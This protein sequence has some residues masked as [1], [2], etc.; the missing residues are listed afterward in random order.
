MTGWSP[1]LSCVPVS[2]GAVGQTTFN[3]STKF[4]ISSCPVTF[5]GQ[6]YEDVY[7][8]F[9]SQNFVVCF[10]G[11]YNPQ[12]GG[13]C[14]LGP[15]T[16]SVFL[17]IVSK[18]QSREQRF[19]ENVP[20][21]HTAMGCN[22][23]YKLAD[24]VSVDTLNVTNTESNGQYYD[25]LDLSGC[26]H[27]GVTYTPD[28][29]VSSDPA[30]CTTLR[31]SRTA[32]LE[33][34]TCGP[35]ETCLSRVCITPLP[36]IC[37][38][39]GPTVIDFSSHLDFVKDRCDYHLLQIQGLSVVGYFLERRLKDV[40]FLDS[41][42]LE[43]NGV[44]IHLKQ[45][46]R[47]LV[48]LLQL[49]FM[50]QSGLGSRMCGLSSFLSVTLRS[51]SL[52][53]QKRSCQTQY[54]DTD[55]RYIHCINKTESCNLLKEAPFTSCPIDPEPYITACTD[56][57]ST[58]P[59]VDGLKCQFLQA[60]VKACSL[61]SNITLDGWGSKAECSSE[62]FCQDRTCSHH[63]FCGEKSDGGETC[64]FC[65]PIFASCYREKKALGDPTVCR[66][67]SASLT[68]I[69]CPLE[70]KGID[71][72]VLHLNNPTCRGQVDEENHMVTFSFNSSSCGT[73][74]TTNNNKVIYKNT[75]ITQNLS[76][77]TI[78]RH[79]QVNIK[80]FCIQTQPD[81][82]TVAFRIKDSSVV[83]EITSGPWTYTLTIKAFTDAHRTQAVNQSTEVFLNQKVW[84]ELDTKGLDGNLV[85]VVTESCWATDQI[86]SSVFSDGSDLITEQ[87]V[88]LFVSSCPNPAD[89]TVR[90]ESNGEGTSS[91][92][93]F[94][95]FEFTG[96]PSEVYLHC[97]LQLCVKQEN[98]C[99]PMCA[100]ARRRR[101]VRS[102]SQSAAF[103]SMAWTT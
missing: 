20:T 78:I 46:G 84:V 68:L 38:L 56:T 34:T 10:D 35:T 47:V 75:I 79:E 58:Y 7:I 18:S 55:D 9:T 97:S 26:R 13:D 33:N 40:S 36:S 31:C 95:M 17:N 50:S 98:S 57:L 49:Q 43:V 52:K 1:L 14:L 91:Y 15:E 80:F 29:D 85:S 99:V 28:T 67:N 44:H 77:S 76:S 60:Y 71:Y 70:D 86:D 96:G 32:V 21:I 30:T 89:P 66:Q 27:R 41:V 74:V 37:T 12:A 82:K 73:E 100:R 54:N 61:F 83:Q 72:S 53:T 5:Y 63:E 62:A 65:R 48:S 103:I 6:K 8:N 69:G 16:S 42:T 90:V 81:I 45:G 87:S 92:F 23:A 11:F 94:N 101:S 24:E 19:L 64:C 51:S 88:F 59:A 102:R 93:S 22:I 3:V 4:N 39:T 25:Y 2:S